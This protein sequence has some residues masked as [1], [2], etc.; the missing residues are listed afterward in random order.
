MQYIY[1]HGFASN[2]KSFKANFFSKKME[3]L[4][5]ELLIPDLNL[6]DFPN[7]TISRQIKTVKDLINTNSSVTLFGSS[8]GGLIALHLAE[9]LENI[10]KLVLLA[11]ALKISK[12]WKNAADEQNLAKW[13]LDDYV[14][15][16]HYGY[17]QN[18]PLKYKF[19]EDL[20]QHNDN[21]FKKIIPTLIFHGLHDTIVPVDF[22]REYAQQKNHI[23]YHELDDDHSLNS[24][25]DYIWQ[26][27]SKFILA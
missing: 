12:L 2:P 22:A 7:L 13:K 8:M 19:Y 14:E 15:I 5:L 17:K 16:Y 1:L 24:K 3:A 25:I 9:Q 26:K 10:E 4:G 21:D 23:E 27:T 11:P 18:M 20:M 6:N